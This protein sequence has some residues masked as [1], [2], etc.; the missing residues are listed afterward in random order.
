MHFANQGAIDLANRVVIDGDHP[1]GT[2]YAAELHVDL[3]NANVKAQ[4]LEV[5]IRFDRANC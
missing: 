1:E 2:C 4:E 5:P 3:D